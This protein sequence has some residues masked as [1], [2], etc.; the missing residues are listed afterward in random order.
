MLNLERTIGL[1]RAVPVTTTI[2]GLSC[3]L[4]LVNDPVLVEQALHVAHPHLETVDVFL[5]PL[6]ELRAEAVVH[7][8]K[9]NPRHVHKAGSFTAKSTTAA[10]T[11]THG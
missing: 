9:K 5:S 10:V 7:L 11:L 8:E 1:T 6:D 3:R 2:G 4:T